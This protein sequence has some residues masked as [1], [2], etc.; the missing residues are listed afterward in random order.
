[1]TTDEKISDDNKVVVNEEPKC[2]SHF[3]FISL[4]IIIALCIILPLGITSNT[5]KHNSH[6]SDN[7]L[8][9]KPIIYYPT[10]QPTSQPT[11]LYLRH[12]F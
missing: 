9:S 6:N 10:S 4:L 12:K 5:Y 1:M 11:Y 3:I 7:E 8:N 2:I